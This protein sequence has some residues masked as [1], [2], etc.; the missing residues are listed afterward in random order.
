MHCLVQHIIAKIL[1]TSCWRHGL[2]TFYSR[3]GVNL[4]CKV[5]RTRTDKIFKIS[6]QIKPIGP[7]IWWFMGP[8][9]CYKIEVEGFILMYLTPTNTVSLTIRVF[10]NSKVEKLRFTIFYFNQPRVH[11]LQ[12]QRGAL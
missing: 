8:C 7:R 2:T 9:K 12:V 4:N 1:I 6:D 5:K 10:F 3:S 11:G